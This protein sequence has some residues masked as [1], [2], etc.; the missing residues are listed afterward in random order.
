MIVVV[1]EVVVVRKGTALFAMNRLVH[2]YVLL[3]VQLWLL[4]FL[5]LIIS[6]LVILKETF[7]QFGLASNL[8]L[9]VLT[10]GASCISVGRLLKLYL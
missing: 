8:F 3:S 9:T 5:K 6:S 1:V 4:E 7:S 2:C 10:E